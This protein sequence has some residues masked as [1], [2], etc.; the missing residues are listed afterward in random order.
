MPSRIQNLLEQTEAE[1]D[2][3]REERERLVGR[4]DVQIKQIEISVTALREAVRAS[5]PPS[6]GMQNSQSKPLFNLPPQQEKQ[7][8]TSELSAAQRVLNFISENPGKTNMQVIEA[9]ERFVTGSK[10]KGPRRVVSAAIWDLK[11]RKK[12]EADEAGKLFIAQD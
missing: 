12:V 7:T 9:L 4:L 6:I 11:M 8:A 3:L 2:S 10:S 1:L 5:G